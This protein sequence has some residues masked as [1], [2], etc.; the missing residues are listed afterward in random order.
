VVTAL[1]MASIWGVVSV[2][3]TPVDST[4]WDVAEL[5]AYARA[6][7]PCKRIRLVG[8]RRLTMPHRTFGQM[9]RTMNP[10]TGI[11]KASCL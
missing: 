9:A 10:V 6:A 4:H 5:F 7:A 1:R 8:S 2:T 3:V 11:P